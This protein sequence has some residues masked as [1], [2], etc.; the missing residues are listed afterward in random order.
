MQGEL[1]P[2]KEN[3]EVFTDGRTLLVNRD[4]NCIGRFTPYA[5]EVLKGE[6]VIFVIF[7]SQIKHRTQKPIRTYR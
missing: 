4:R 5:Y 7:K 2:E 1:A 3:V 6:E